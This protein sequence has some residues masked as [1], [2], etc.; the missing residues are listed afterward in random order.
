MIDQMCRDSIYN[1]KCPSQCKKLAL[2]LKKLESCCNNNLDILKRFYRQPT[3][4]S[5]EI[6]CW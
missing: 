6:K 2:S 1:K 4:L 3:V 5:F